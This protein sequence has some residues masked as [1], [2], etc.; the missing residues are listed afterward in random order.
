MAFEVNL[1]FY[2]KLFDKILEGV[3]LVDWKGKVLFANKAAVKIVG[4]KELVNHNIREFIAKESLTK[5]LKDLA[6][7]KLGWGGELTD[8]KLKNGA[9]VR[10]LGHKVGLD[11]KKAI[12]VTMRDITSLKKT[13]QELKERV[14]EL[15]I[16]YNF[17]RLIGTE[18]DLEGI[19]K[20]LVRII[21][22]AFQ[23]PELACARIKIGGEEYA[24]SNFKKTSYC[25]SENLV[26]EEG[27][28]QVCYLKK[29]DFLEEEEEL[30]QAIAKRLSRVI[31]Q[32]RTENKYQMLTESTNDIIYSMTPE[33]VVDYISPQVRVYGYKPDYFIGKKFF[34]IVAPEDREKVMKD[35][36]KTLETGEEF[37]TEF[38]IKDSEGD[39]VWLEEKGRVVYEDGKPVKIIG[40]IRDVTEQKNYETKLKELKNRYEDLF[41]ESSDL[42]QSC[43]LEGKLVEVNKAWLES[44]GYEHDEVVGRDFLEFIHES[45]KDKCLSLFKKV[46]KGESL[47]SIKAVFKKK[48]GSKL[49]VNGV[50]QPVKKKGEITG[51]WGQFRD[52]TKERLLERER[53]EKA[54]N[55]L[56]NHFIMRVSHEL[57]HPLMPIVGF[58]NEL[59]EKELSRTEQEKYLKRII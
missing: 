3:V 54:I 35:A 37:P 21:P 22:P 28:I 43:D 50:A 6:K 40:V 17:S 47:E 36:K 30:L 32:K 42:I 14:K 1:G 15:R 19:Y 8:Y 10:G 48:D 53:Q 44:M 4:V 39:V 18:E 52:V 7:V 34:E 12:L 38:R 58:A 49:F 13:E 55:K 25:L 51:S 29:K 59:L 57:R 16:L 45:S 33:G 31:E 24:T 56:K 9:W 23:H 5:A 2:K 27:V 41:H 20:G 11:G 26:G 46:M